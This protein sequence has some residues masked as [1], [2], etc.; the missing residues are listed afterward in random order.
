MHPYLIPLKPHL[1][2]SSINCNFSIKNQI[3]NSKFNK[4]LSLFLASPFYKN[5]LFKNLKILAFIPKQA[6]KKNL[7]EN[8]FKDMNFLLNKFHGKNK[9]M[10]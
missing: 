4:V 9:R 3:I 7:E 10:V 6:F 5:Y 2:Q 8:I 1:R